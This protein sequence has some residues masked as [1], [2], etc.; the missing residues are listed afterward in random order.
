MSIINVIFDTEV[1]LCDYSGRW[2]IVS[3]IYD[4]ASYI[5]KKCP[6]MTTM[7][8][9]KLVYYSYAEYASYTGQPMFDEEFEAWRNGP[10]LRSL[11]AYHRGFY[12]AERSLF[13]QGAELTDFEKSIIDTVIKKY[14]SMSAQ[15]LSQKTHMESPWLDARKG[16][17]PY[18]NSDAKISF[19]SVYEWT[20]H[21]A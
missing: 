18:D 15:Q 6:L 2:C 17:S 9:Q 16:L 1:F 10:V 11:Y 14:A 7:K 4:V 21:Y 13:K 8:L 19:E 20:K 3:K 12:I 5:V